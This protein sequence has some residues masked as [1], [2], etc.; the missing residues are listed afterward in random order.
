MDL[1]R[2]DGLGQRTD[3]ELVRLLVAGN[4]DAMTVIFDRYYRLVM[5]VALRIMED[6]AEAEDVVQTVF[7]HFYQRAILFDEQKGKLGSWLLQYAYGRSINH[8][9]SLKARH[10][11]EQSELDES[12]MDHSTGASP[13]F[14][15]LHTSD[16]VRLVEQILPHLNERQR[17]VI[18][19]VFFEGMKASEVASETGESLGNVLHAYYRGMEKLRGYLREAE[20][21][22]LQNTRQRKSPTA[23]E[24]LGV[25][26][27]IAKTRIL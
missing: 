9:K 22:A 4:H 27:Q 8:K 18:E 7:T 12:K 2:P 6:V 14:L 17:F 26:V 20:D 16:A 11:Y 3:G 1:A 24:T 10:F 23:T 5:S 13:R 15:N 25:E 21:T 19:R